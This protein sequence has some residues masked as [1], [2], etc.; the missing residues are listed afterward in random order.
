MSDDKE[1]KKTAKTTDPTAVFGEMYEKMMRQTAEQ[2]EEV[3][4]NPLFLSAMSANVDQNLSLQNQM[5]KLI[6]T[7]LAAMNLPT[8][9]DVLALGQKI[10]KLSEEISSL[11]QKSEVK[12]S[13]AGRTRA[14]KQ[15]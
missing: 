5:Q 15:S 11:R 12:T 9:N 7:T 14:K 3:A 4:R 2:W 8:R 1:R 6:E 13:A 10:D